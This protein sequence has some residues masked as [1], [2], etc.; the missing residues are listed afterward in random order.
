MTVTILE[1]CTYNLFSIEHQYTKKA[2]VKN[3]V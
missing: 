2:K 3:P 1:K